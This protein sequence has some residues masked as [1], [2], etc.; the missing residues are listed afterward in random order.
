[1]WLKMWAGGR[2]HYKELGIS[3]KGN[4]KPLDS[5]KQWSAK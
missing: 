1:M 2:S 3:S 4:G 5:F